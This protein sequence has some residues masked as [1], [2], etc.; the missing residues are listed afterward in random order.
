MYEATTISKTLVEKIC[1]I[2]LGILTLSYF[3]ERFRNFEGTVISTW[4]T[5]AG[6]PGS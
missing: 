6:N 3:R 1:N 5:P 2:F 4:H